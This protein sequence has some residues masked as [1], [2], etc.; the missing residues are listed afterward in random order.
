M[1]TVNDETVQIEPGGTEDFSGTVQVWD[2]NPQTNDFIV[3]YWVVS[4]SE[5]ETYNVICRRIETEVLAGTRNNTC[6]KF[7]PIIPKLAV[8][9]PDWLINFGNDPFVEIIVPGDTITSFA[10]H[11]YPENLDGCSQLEFR[12]VTE[13]DVDLIYTSFN[14]GFRHGCQIG[15]EELNTVE[16]LSLFPNPTRGNVQIDLMEES[17]LLEIVV[18]N[19]V[20]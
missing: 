13:D 15:I 7:C 3:D 14:L 19:S 8:E 1:G 17:K 16:E 2:V 18:V 12:F 11:Y 5:T 10:Q 20:G 6:W 9:E 4:E